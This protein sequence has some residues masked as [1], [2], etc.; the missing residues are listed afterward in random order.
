MHVKHSRVDTWS[1]LRQALLDRF[2]GYQTE[3]DLMQELLQREQNANEGVDDYIHHMR[4]LASR[5]QKPLR[6]RELVKIIKRGLKESLAK[7]V[8]AIDVVTVDELRQECIE[9]ERNARRRTRSGYAQ[10]TRY[11][12]GVKPS[13]HECPPGEP[14]PP[15]EDLDE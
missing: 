5:F 9:V 8:Y 10:H 14:E 3:H 11:S 7:Y 6:D 12:H 1:H 2:H 13:V 4:Q 15:P